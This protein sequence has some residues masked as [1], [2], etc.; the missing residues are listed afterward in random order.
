MTIQQLLKE[1]NISRYQ[2]AQ[3]SGVPWSTLS[4]I[5][6]GKTDLSRCSARTLLKLS[7]ALNIPMEQLMSLTGEH[8]VPPNSKL[9]A[10][11]YSE[12]TLP[13]SPEKG[14]PLSLEKALA[15]Y[16][17]GEKDKV[18]YTDCLWGEL[19]GA[20]NSSQWSN[21]ITKE[22]ADYLREKYLW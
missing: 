5:C 21:E 20:I 1:K 18:S 12:E 2:L 10:M 6:S 7:N 19:Y 13:A 15:E 9:Q 11:A 16:I 22:Q 17:Q 3:I 4:D 8:P 14:L